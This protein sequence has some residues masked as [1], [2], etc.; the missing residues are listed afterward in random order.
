MTDEIQLLTR[1]QLKAQR[2]K[3]APGQ[4]VAKRY[5]A[6]RIKV[7]V[8]LYDPALAVPMKAYKAPSEKQAEAL[9]KGRFIASTFECQGCKE[10]IDNYLMIANCWCSA[11]HLASTRATTAE[12]ARAILALNPLFLD[13]ETTGLDRDAEIVEIAVIDATGT[14]L[15]NTLVKPTGTIP[16]EA[17]A[18]HGIT[19]EHVQDAPA[20]GEIADQV[21]AILAGRSIVSH[22]SSFDRPF[23]RE[24][25]ANAG[26]EQTDQKWHCSMMILV[27]ENDGRWPSLGLAMC[28]AEVDAEGLGSA[29]RALSDAEACRR[30]IKAL[31]AR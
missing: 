10:R 21:H 28:L 22:N 4:E 9:A 30:V 25:L 17:T 8:D 6:N 15:L 26:F 27:D 1:T 2:L 12:D 20:F 24:A 29:H 13:V 3:P 14:V 5:Y 11:C 7:W 31:A 19:P 18:V 23:V 16:G